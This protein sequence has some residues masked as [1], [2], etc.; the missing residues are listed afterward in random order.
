MESPVTVI[1]AAQTIS[2]AIDEA[3]EDVGGLTGGLFIDAYE[4]SPDERRLTEVS[5]ELINSSNGLASHFWVEFSTG[6][7]FRISVTPDPA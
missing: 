6:Q 4:Q 7:R 3:Q 1:E 2:R 5:A